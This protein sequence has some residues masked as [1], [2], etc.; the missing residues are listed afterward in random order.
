MYVYVYASQ[1]LDTLVDI[2]VVY[3]A[4]RI[5]AVTQLFGLLKSLILPL[6]L[7]LSLFFSRHY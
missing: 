5:I 1:M 4:V 2:R 3:V 7:Y 6:T